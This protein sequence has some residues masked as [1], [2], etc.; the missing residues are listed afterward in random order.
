MNASPTSIPM[1]DTGG[2]GETQ[3]GQGAATS[4]LMAR[5]GLITAHWATVAL[6]MVVVAV[7]GIE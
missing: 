1:L 7:A 5:N 2:G 3:T 6:A 4:A